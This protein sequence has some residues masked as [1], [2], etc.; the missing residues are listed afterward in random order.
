[1]NIWKQNG[2]LIGPIEKSNL[3]MEDLQNQLI[4]KIN[5]ISYYQGNLIVNAQI[6]IVIILKYIKLT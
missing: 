1:M 6:M 4:L 3:K 5:L 2:T